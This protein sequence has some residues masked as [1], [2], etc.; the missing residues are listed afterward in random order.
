MSSPLKSLGGAIVSEP[1]W[2]GCLSLR[3]GMV[4]FSKRWER[5]L[6]ASFFNAKDWRRGRR[7]VAF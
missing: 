2:G 1:A 3:G 4:L 6:K 5:V 7:S